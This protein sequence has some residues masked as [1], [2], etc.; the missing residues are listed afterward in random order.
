MNYD[1]FF[2]YYKELYGE[3]TFYVLIL[4]SYRPNLEYK[5]RSLFESTNIKL[6]DKRLN[7]I[8]EGVNVPAELINERYN[9]HKIGMYEVINSGKMTL[10]NEKE[11]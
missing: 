5:K 8:S 11:Y 1:E 6:V 9:S 4:T 10:I 2:K 3:Q 7:E